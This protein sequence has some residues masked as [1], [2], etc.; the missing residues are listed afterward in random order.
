MKKVIV[1]A[2]AGAVFLFGQ[3]VDPDEQGRPGFPP[4]LEQFL[5]LEPGQVDEIKAANETFNEYLK[6]KA[7][8]RRGWK[9]QLK[10][11]LNQEV[12][13]VGEIGQ[14]MVNIE[15]QNREIAGERQELEQTLQELLNEDQLNR[16]QA[17]ERAMRLEPVANQAVRVRLL[18]PPKVR[19]T[20]PDEE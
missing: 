11:A 1:L 4:Q 12:M 5:N 15:T 3:T 9:Q 19:K 17:L 20:L 10:E 8:I 16:L 13:N 18:F 2:L 6:L 14:L 7:E